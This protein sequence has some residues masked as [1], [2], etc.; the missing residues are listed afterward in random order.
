MSDPNSDLIGYEWTSPEPTGILVCRV[1]RTH[2]FLP[3]YVVVAC[4]AAD[5]KPL[6]TLRPAAI[7][8]RHKELMDK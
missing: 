1:L 3:T 5:D 6:L 4:Q 8:R 2:S 7:V